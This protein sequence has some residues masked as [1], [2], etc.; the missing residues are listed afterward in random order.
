MRVAVLGLSDFGYPLAIRLHEI[1]NEV[2]AVDRNREPVQRIKDFVTKAVVADV[3]DR[4]ALDELGIG[5]VDA[6]MV[7]IGRRLEAT[8]LLTHYLKQAGVPRIFVKV[9]DEEQGT[10]LRLIGASD[11][12]QPDRDIAVR[13]AARMTFPHFIDGMFLG[14]ESR[15]VAVKALDRWVGSTLKEFDQLKRAPVRVI[16]V[17][18]ARG[19]MLPIVPGP[20]YRIS[21]NDTIILLG[22]V[23]ELL[24]EVRK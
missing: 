9:A 8:L 11:V 5:E 13:I 1:G 7:T 12:V 21:A 18:P 19:G 2:I 6:V 15:I 22:T 17:D 23:Q 4:A 14:E 16:A 20:D 10:I 24:R 3:T